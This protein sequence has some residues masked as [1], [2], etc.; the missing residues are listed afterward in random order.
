[1]AVGLPVHRM[2]DAAHPA[3]DGIGEIGVVFDQEQAHEDGNESPL[4]LMAL[5][6][7]VFKRNNLAL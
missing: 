4:S 1:L 7:E 3:D 5:M 6:G 2:A